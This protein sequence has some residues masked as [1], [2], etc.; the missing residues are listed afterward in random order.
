MVF[1][2]ILIIFYHAKVDPSTQKGEN[3][4]YNSYKQ[5]NMPAHDPQHSKNNGTFV[6]INLQP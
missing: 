2:N 6:K 5:Q 3:L 4:T 1:N